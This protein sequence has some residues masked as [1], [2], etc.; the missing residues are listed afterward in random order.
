MNMD[1]KEI[2]K[3]VKERKKIQNIKNITR[4]CKEKL[5]NDAAKKE[6]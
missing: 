6:K 2:Q 5:F 1:N 3:Q 4:A